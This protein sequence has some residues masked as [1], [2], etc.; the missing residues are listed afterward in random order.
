ML[1]SFG[2]FPTDALQGLQ[3]SFDLFHLANDY[4]PETGTLKLPIR[5]QKPQEVPFFSHKGRNQDIPFHG[6]LLRPP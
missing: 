6:Y 2:L 5:A 3:E 4:V 1:Q